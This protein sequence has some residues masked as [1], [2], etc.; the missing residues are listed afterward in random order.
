LKVYQEVH[1]L[2]LTNVYTLDRYWEAG[3]CPHL[4]LVRTGGEVAYGGALLA[5][6]H[7]KTA[8]STFTVPTGVSTV[9]IAELEDEV[10]HVESISLDDEVHRLG[11]TLTR[12][13]V[14]EFAVSAGVIVRIVGWY[15]SRFQ[16][17]A[18][19]ENGFRRAM[20]VDEFIH[21]NRVS[22]RDNL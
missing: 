5:A 13:Q 9:L 21:H 1:E 14:L 3:C 20:L 22:E 11:R 16:S 4:F 6:G 17:L 12:G 15:A 18:V 7:S 2:D 10:T 19:N 8:I